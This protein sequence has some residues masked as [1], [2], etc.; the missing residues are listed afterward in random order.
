MSFHELIASYPWLVKRAMRVLEQNPQVPRRNPLAYLL[1]AFVPYAGKVGAG[2]GFLLYVYF[3]GLTAA[4]A[5]PAYQNYTV[6][7]A[8]VTAMTAS[9]P[10]RTALAAYYETN[11]Q[12]P[13]SLDAAGIPSALPNGVELRLDTKGMILHVTA[14]IGEL[15]FVPKLDDQG[16]VYWTCRPGAGLRPEIVPISC[17]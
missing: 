15:L 8:L 14:K 1:A 7:T 11:K 4:V 12:V 5:I 16:R 13:A 10:A 6:R 17:R 9:D 3:I 2:I